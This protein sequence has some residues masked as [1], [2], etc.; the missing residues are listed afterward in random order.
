[1]NGVYSDLFLDYDTFEINNEI[2]KL[3][4][5][6]NPQ[7]FITK[8]LANWNYIINDTYQLIEKNFN[9]NENIIE[10]KN[11]IIKEWSNRYRIYLTT[12][13]EDPKIILFNGLCNFYEVVSFC[14]YHHQKR[15]LKTYKFKCPVKLENKNQ[16]FDEHYFI[17]FE[18]V[19]KC[20]YDH[21]VKLVNNTSLEYNYI[22]FIGENKPCGDLELVEKI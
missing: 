7:Y 20:S 8:A 3:E 21:D 2:E 15:L 10:S 4:Y 11:A 18:S 6:D 12:L 1:M 5:N 22:G 19:T 14:N 9:G 13:L 16:Q 17:F